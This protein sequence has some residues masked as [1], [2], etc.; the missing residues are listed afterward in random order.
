MQRQSGS[1]LNGDLGQG[2]LEVP[3]TVSTL[4]SSFRDG[5]QGHVAEG[6]DVNRGKISSPLSY[7]PRGDFDQ[8]PEMASAVGGQRPNNP[9]QYASRHRDHR[10]DHGP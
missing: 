7:A 2:A 1:R 9:D 6:A 4:Q 8:S 3:S 5:L 10:P